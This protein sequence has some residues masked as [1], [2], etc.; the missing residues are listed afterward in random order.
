MIEDTHGAVPDEESRGPSCKAQFGV[1]YP[2]C[3]SCK[4]CVNYYMS[5]HVGSVLYKLVLYFLFTTG[6]SE[7]EYSYTL[8]KN[9][10]IHVYLCQSLSCRWQMLAH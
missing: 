7:Y 5:F 4:A 1:N 6:F 9:M 2:V 3:T 10:H 8:G